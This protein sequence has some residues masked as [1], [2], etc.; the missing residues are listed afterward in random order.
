L[1]QRQAA[2]TNTGHTDFHRFIWNASVSKKF[3]K[4]EGLKLSLSA[5]DLLNKNVGFNRTADGNLITQSNYTTIKR[6]FMAS[7][8]WD[9]N[10]MGGSPT[11]K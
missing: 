5:N 2:N 10:K 7:V 1:K 9:F 4:S 8:S 11:K 3:L 6:Y